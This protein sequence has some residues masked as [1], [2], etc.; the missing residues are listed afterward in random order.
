M[1]DHIWRVAFLIYSKNG[2][3]EEEEGHLDNDV[4]G[5]KRFE[6]REHVC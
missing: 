6:N 3:E 2:L 5:W 4:F 1:F